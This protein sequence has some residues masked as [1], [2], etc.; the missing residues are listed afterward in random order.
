MKELLKTKKYAFAVSQNPRIF[1]IDD[2][3]PA[4]LRIEISMWDRIP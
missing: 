3:D 1:G 2:L 4:G